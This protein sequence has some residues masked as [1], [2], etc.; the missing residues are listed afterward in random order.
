MTADYVFLF[1]IELYARWN[2]DQYQVTLVVSDPGYGSLDP[3]RLQNQTCGTPY[4]LD[5][6]DLIIGK[7]IRIKPTPSN[8]SGGNTYEFKGW[9][10]G[11][12]EVIN[13]TI[14]NAVTFTA[15]FVKYCEV[16]LAASEKGYGT[17]DPNMVA[18]RLEGTKYS[19]DG[20]TLT[21]GDT[22]V[23][24]TPAEA[25]DGYAYEFAGWFVGDEE[26]TAGTIESPV[27]FTAR[28][29]KYCAVTLKVS[30]EG[31]GSLDPAN[32]GQQP[33]GTQ[34][35]VDG[36]TLTIGNTD[37]KAAPAEAG[38]GYVYGFAGWFIGDNEV[39]SGTITDPVTFTAKFVKNHAVQ[40]P[41]A[42]TGLTYNGKTQ[43]GVPSGEGY[44]V[45]NGK[46]KDAGSYTA[47]LTLNDGYV[48]SD[49]ETTSKTIK[50]SISKA[51]LIARY[52]G[53]TVTEGFTP[54]YDVTVSGFVGGE[55]P[56]TA[57]KYVAPEVSCPDLSVGSYTLTPSG[58]SAKNYSF[59]YASGVLTVEA[60]PDAAVG[61]VFAVNGLVYEI[62]S[63]DPATAS[64]VRYEGSPAD[65][66]VP[67]AV[68][69]KE[70]AFQV[71]SVGE[72][73][74]YGCATLRSLD[75]GTV[76]D[77]GF[78]AFADCPS[79]RD[80][81]IPDTLKPVGG[82]AFYGCGIVSLDIPGD[83]VVLER[84]AFSAC[85]R[86]KTITF[87]GPGTVIGPYAFY[88]DSGLTSVDLSNVASVGTKAFPYCDG[89]TSLT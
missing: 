60:L 76:K 88:R 70:G 45:A 72:K 13:G 51:V 59:K 73:A 21:I 83:G 36:D 23:K 25:G 89:I 11:D 64:L 78:K 9:F 79:L 42:A 6:N 33:E 47:T 46:A 27:A 48:W 35:S 38:D 66:V 44:A 28:F 71:A 19:V 40:V 65:V 43:T 54:A 87:S 10:I 15:R 82:Y 5:S 4:E 69:F 29:V 26:A 18:D 53:E 20:D 17:L 14:V 8:A 52:A 37:V 74:F 41:S 63:L 7:T 24:A 34:Y 68:P 85:A 31:Y 75:L 3:D 39:T 80:L 81:T 57:S 12:K 84:S 86:M 30:E 1:D 55:T 61:V 67:E 32:I 49:G 77:V 2:L 22:D 62:T 16:T 56:S 50:W 58:G